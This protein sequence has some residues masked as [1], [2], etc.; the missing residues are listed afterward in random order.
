MSILAVCDMPPKETL[1]YEFGG[2]LKI[3]ALFKLYNYIC[4]Y[5]NFIAFAL[6]K[7]LHFH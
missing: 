6:S 5:P 7:I 2:V 3:I 1:L 4:P